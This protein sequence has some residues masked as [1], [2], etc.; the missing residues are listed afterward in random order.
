MWGA[1]AGLYS[2]LGGT[3]LHYGKPH[4][5]LYQTCFTALAGIS[6][7]RILAVGDSFETDMP[8]AKDAG[9]DALFIQSGIHGDVLKNNLSGGL[10]ALCAEHD[11]TP[12]AALDVFRW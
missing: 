4:L 5:P 12:K 11:C 1:V 8:G 7:D 6:K 10:Q 3:S 9:I 2:S